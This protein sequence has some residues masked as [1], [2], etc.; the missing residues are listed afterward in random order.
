MKQFEG[1]IRALAYELVRGVL[2][3]ELMRRAP[4]AAARWPAKRP[5]RAAAK[6]V[7][8]SGAQAAKPETDAALAR[9]AK[10]PVDVAQVV[11]E[12]SIYAN[13][14]RRTW[15]RERVINELARWLMAGGAI[16]AAFVARHGPP[17][18]VAGAKRLFGRFDAA[19]DAAILHLARQHPDGVPSKQRATAP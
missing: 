18:L 8:S 5:I 14:K 15:T 7:E 2:A 16:E 17:G 6:P 13:G 9:P 3:A 11:A 19:L 4:P 1:E 10:R 12:S